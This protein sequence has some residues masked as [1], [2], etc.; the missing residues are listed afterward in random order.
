MAL[1][2]LFVLVL[3][4]ALSTAAFAADATTQPANEPADQ[5]TTAELREQ[6]KQLQA[7]VEQ[8]EAKQNQTSADVAATVDKIV[9]DAS[10]RS[11]LL[12]GDGNMVGGWNAQKQQFYLGSADGNFYFHPIAIFQFRGNVD[13]RED[14][15]PSGGSSTEEGF[16]IR[17][18]KFGFDGNMFTPDLTYKFQWQDNSVGSPGLEYAWVQYIFAHDA[19]VPNGDLA[20]RAGQSKD[21]V[22][23]EEFT[24]DPVQLMTERSLANALVGGNAPPSNLLQGVDLLLIGKDNPLH[25]EI[26]LHDGYGSGN[27]NFTE[28]H[29]TSVTFPQSPADPPTNPGYWG[30]SARVDYKVFG[31]WVDTTDLTGRNSGKHDLL[32]IGAGVDYTDA[33]GAGAIRYTVDAQY[34]L[35]RKLAFLVAG[36]G[37]HFDFRDTAAGVAGAQNNFGAQVEGG[38]SLNSAWQL[39]AR[40]SVSKLD[41]EFE[42][43][44]TSTFQEY[45]VGANWFGPN[46]AWGNHAKFTV[47]LNYLPEGSPSEPGLDYLASPGNAQIVLRTQFQ[48]WL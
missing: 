10:R 15:K 36:Y 47:D 28:P 39:I 5:P 7:K 35:A 18:A 44:G 31:D 8:L 20:I 23:K 26:M 29:G 43:D 9:G 46:G 13:Y 25:A 17:R 2:S 12:V 6:I 11:Q 24:G 37:D 45:S 33:Q 14:A 1:R 4:L 21:I 27:T 32:T 42:I 41:D 19:V 3:T 40:Y 30:A 34:Q 16:E 22:F 48:L 38:Y